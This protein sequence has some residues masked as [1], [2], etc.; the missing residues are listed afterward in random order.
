M[1]GM[2]DGA[3]VATAKIVADL[4]EVLFREPTS[5]EDS[6]SAGGH[7]GPMPGRAS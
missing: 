5:Q 7:H 3:M 6:Y 4:L 1:V 2:H